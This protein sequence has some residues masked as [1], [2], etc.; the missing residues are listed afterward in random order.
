MKKIVLPLLALTCM[1]VWTAFGAEVKT[2]YSHSVDFSRYHTYSWIKV[3][4]D[5]LWEDR[6]TEAVEKGLQAKGWTRVASGGD[7]GVT[8][9]GATHEQPTPRGYLMRQPR[10][11]S[12]RR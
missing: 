6:I 9:F 4:T 5:P 2:D 10:S 11:G 1:V 7:V 12:Q 3:K 8:A